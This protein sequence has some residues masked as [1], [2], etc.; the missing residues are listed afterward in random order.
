MLREDQNGLTSE[1]LITSGLADQVSAIA[2]YE[3][4]IWKLRVGYVLVLNGAL[5]LALKGSGNP[6]EILSNLRYSHPLFGI[7]VGISLTFF[8]I[9]FGYVRKKLKFVVARELLIDLACSQNFDPRDSRVKECLKEILHIA[10]ESRPTK[11]PETAKSEYYEKRRWNLFW[12]LL[13]IYTALPI[14]CVLFSAI[15]WIQ[16]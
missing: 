14:L 3:S 5:A 13:P 11:L 6:L 2:G 7:V 4:V 15:S 16:G 9:D 12:I 8:L 10:G 1:R